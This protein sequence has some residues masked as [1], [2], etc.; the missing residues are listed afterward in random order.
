M[1]RLATALAVLLAAALT[2]CGGTSAHH[3]TTGAGTPRPIATDRGP[4]DG[5]PVRP[6][7]RGAYLGAYAKPDP[8]TQPGRIMAVDDLQ[9]QLGRRL[10]VVHTYRKWADPFDTASDRAFQAG[11]AVLLYSWAGTDTHQITAGRYDG[12]IARRARQIRAMGRPVLLEWRWEMDR[13][14]LRAQMGSPAEYVAAWRHLRGVFAAQHVTN[15][16]W[17]WC[18][19]ADGFAAGGDAPAF[20]PGDDEVDWLC[21]DA[22]PGRRVRPLS[23][24]LAPF[25]TWAR[26]HR[27]PIIVGEYGAPKSY[28]PAVRAEWLRGAAAEFKANPQIRAA[29]YYDSDPDRDRPVERY[30]LRGD[31]AALRAFA[32]MARD[33]WFNPKS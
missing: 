23:T 24:V 31:P 19:T 6:P 2:G 29:C 11:G 27:K 15:A 10:D 13:P 16:S 7:A 30:A 1:R 3:T 22:Y 9:G 8:V 20:Y 21:V 26:G 5:G 28:G 12:L 14:N 32:D 25:L 4:L 17:V 18:P 33:P